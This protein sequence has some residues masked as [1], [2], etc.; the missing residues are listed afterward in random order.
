MT[1][2]A[3]DD[4]GVEMVCDE[5]V[6][7]VTDYLEGTLSAIDRDRFERHIRECVWCERYLEQT[8]AVIAAMGELGSEPDDPAAL[9][10][11]LIE[12]R[13]AHAGS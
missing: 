3:G 4:T 2:E 11:A 13:D 5:L 6:G 9:E 12:F 10:R 1:E 7:L 8:R